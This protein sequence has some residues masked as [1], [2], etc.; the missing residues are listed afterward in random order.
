MQLALKYHPRWRYTHRDTESDAETKQLAIALTLL[1]GEEML[2]ALIKSARAAG[3]SDL[4]LEAGL[5]PVLR[6][7]GELIRRGDPVEANMLESIG[8]RLTGEAGWPRFVEQGSFDLSANIAGVRCRINIF[9]TF[10]GLSMAIRVFSTVEPTLKKLN[11]H[12]D[13]MSITE[14]SHGLVLISGPTGS[15]KSSTMAALIQ[16]INRKQSKHIL[17]IESPIEYLF[18]MQR[19][20]IRQREVGRDTPSFY[21]GLI[22]ALREDPDVLMV[23]EMREPDVMRQ[24]LG[25][26]E[27][28][29]LV[30][31]TV[32]SGT[33][34]EA[35]QRIVCAFPAEVQDGIRAQLADTLQ[36]VVC[37]RLVFMPEQH[38]RVPECEILFGNLTAKSVVREGKYHKLGDVIQTGAQERM[39]SFGRYRTWINSRTDWYIGHEKNDQAP[40]LDDAADARAALLRTLKPENR[41]QVAQTPTRKIQ[42]RPPSSPA[43]SKSSSPGRQAPVKKAKTYY[44]INDLGNESAEEILEALKNMKK[45]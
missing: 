34:A 31:A 8:R 18:R 42:M 11:L 4:H 16:E 36:A 41:V 29:H 7:G 33:V 1:E 23:G 2:G 40:S 20:F 28:G 6:I 27:T 45:K 15:G 19:A 22:D 13:L 9:R 12:P 32:H 38:L 5:P 44:E 17:T 10:R 3:A 35:L 26:A 24:T 37:Q 43:T 39:W 14:C 30:F 21:Q 25:A